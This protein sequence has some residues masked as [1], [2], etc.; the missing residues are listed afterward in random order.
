[1]LK[2]AVNFTCVALTVAHIAD[3]SHIH[4]RHI[5]SHLRLENYL[6]WFAQ[7]CVK[8]F[9]IKYYNLINSLNITIFIYI[10]AVFSEKIHSINEWTI[11]FKKNDRQTFLLPCYRVLCAGKK[12]ASILGTF[13]PKAKIAAKWSDLVKKVIALKCWP[14][15]V[16]DK[17]CLKLRH[18]ESDSKAIIEP[19]HF[20]RVILAICP[21]IRITRLTELKK[22]KP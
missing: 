8:I 20:R 21:P 11:L 18:K 22:F 19:I 5:L 4:T 7:T 10:L 12:F 6:N 3:S 15:L 14:F 9:V 16:L 13:Y 17:M 1:M 2:S